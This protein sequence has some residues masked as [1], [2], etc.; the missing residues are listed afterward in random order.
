MSASDGCGGDGLEV[1]VRHVL[2][3]AGDVQTK[4]LKIAQQ[5]AKKKP[6]IQAPV[7]PRGGDIL[8]IENKLDFSLH[9]PGQQ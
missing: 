2:L 4:V 9:I 8:N 6:L 7:F 3:L 1:L 5:T